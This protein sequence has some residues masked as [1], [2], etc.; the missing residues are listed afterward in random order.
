MEHL[1]GWR[2]YLRYFP[3]CSQW[4]GAE[5]E[6]KAMIKTVNEIQALFQTPIQAVTPPRNPE[7][8]AKDR[9]S[10]LLE[11]MN[12]AFAAKQWATKDRLALRILALARA[13]ARNGGKAHFKIGLAF[14]SCRAFHALQPDKMQTHLPALQAELTRHL[15]GINL[16]EGL[17]ATIQKARQRA[18]NARNPSIGVQ[19]TVAHSVTDKLAKPK[20]SG[21]RR[22]AGKNNPRQLPSAPE[23]NPAMA[24]A[25]AAAGV[26]ADN[27]VSIA[28]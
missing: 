18:A 24:E 5:N 17:A 14:T 10:T 15:S 23:T 27:V 1:G 4:L 6:E 25:L 19:K 21:D 20:Q 28:A 11:Q 3:R 9:L 13:S 7:A 8:D 26:T 12:A 22:P 2:R 16:P